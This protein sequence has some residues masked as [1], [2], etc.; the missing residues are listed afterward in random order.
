VLSLIPQGTEIET[1]EESPKY[2]Y[3]WP[4]LAFVL[5]SLALKTGL[6]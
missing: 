6:Q 5:A 3:D 1:K 2:Y 4:V